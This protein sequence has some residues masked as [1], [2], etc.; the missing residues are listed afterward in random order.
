MNARLKYLPI[1]FHPMAPTF[2]IGAAVFTGLLL[3][4]HPMFLGNYLLF[5]TLAELFAIVVAC[6]IFMLAWNARRMLDNDFLLFLGVAYLFVAGLDLLHTLAYDGVGVFGDRGVNPATQFWISARSVEALSLLAAFL[7]LNRRLPRTPVFAIYGVVFALLTGSILRW[8]IFPA[9]FVDGEGLTPF[10]QGMEY[11]IIAVLG[12]ALGLLYYNRLRFDGQVVRLMAAAVVLTMFAELCFTL[13]TRPDGFFN[14]LGHYFKLASFWFI[15]KALIETGL[16]QPYQLLYR[17]L[18][19]GAAALRIERDQLERRVEERTADL[20]RAVAKLQRRTAQ[21][22]RLAALLT[23][24]EERE[25]RRL[26]QVL[27]D[28]LQ[29]LLVAARMQL[30]AACQNAHSLGGVCEFHNSIDDLIREAIEATRTLSVELNPPILHESGLSAALPWL[31][32]DLMKKFGIEVGLEIDPGA[33]PAGEELRVALFAAVRELL[34]NVA[35]HS[36]AKNAEVRMER[37]NDQVHLT[38]RDHGAGFDAG[39]EHENFGMLSIRERMDM[40]GGGMMVETAPGKG[41]LVELAAPLTSV[42]H[43]PAP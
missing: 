43:A 29:Q 21:L 30:A 13:Y 3:I 40:L 33:E 18:K 27:H 22:R 8:E 4:W 12:V 38:V 11:L 24:A 2:L 31:A 20:R 32:E 34:L 23:K 36:G 1:S 15:Y 37:R 19:Q 41:V 42:E 26:A 28:H 7:F 17:E 9:C 6:S 14:M 5:H 39:A 10:K 35:K 25:R 16:R